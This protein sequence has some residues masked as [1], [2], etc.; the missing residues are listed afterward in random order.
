MVQK[1]LTTSNQIKNTFKEARV[2]LSTIKRHLNNELYDPCATTG[3]RKA[4][5]VSNTTC[6]TLGK[7]IDETIMTL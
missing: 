3:N 5:K 2:S 4:K 6:T 1:H 7:K